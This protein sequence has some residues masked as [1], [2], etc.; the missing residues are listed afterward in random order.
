[1]KQQA[2]DKLNGVDLASEGL[3]AI[4]LAP[5][6]VFATGNFTLVHVFMLACFTKLDVCSRHGLRACHKHRGLSEQLYRVRNRHQPRLYGLGRP[7]P[8]GCAGN[9]KKK[10]Y[11][12]A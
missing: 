8:T 12:K 10:G 2:I 4:V 3:I 6:W 1:M 5:P 7:L 9:G 11:Y